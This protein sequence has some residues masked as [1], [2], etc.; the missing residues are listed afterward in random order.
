M[1]KHVTGRVYDIS[2]RSHVPMSMS[3]CP[4]VPMDMYI[5]SLNLH[6][7]LPTSHAHPTKVTAV[8]FVAWGALAGREGLERPWSP[9]LSRSALDEGCAIL[10]GSLG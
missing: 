10:L 8:G 7:C 4:Q 3:A 5:S 6:I 2:E 1:N 9:H